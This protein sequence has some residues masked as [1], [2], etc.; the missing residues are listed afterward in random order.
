M[1]EKALADRKSDRPNN[2]TKKKKKKKKKNNNN[3]NNDRGHWDPF[4]GTINLRTS[5]TS[6]LICL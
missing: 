4:P 6:L 1:N 5:G 2:N 3:N